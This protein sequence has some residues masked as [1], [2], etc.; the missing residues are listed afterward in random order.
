MD[1]DLRN[2][3][4]AME[5]RFTACMTETEGRLTARM[6]DQHE[7][8]LNRLASL[9]SDFQNIKGLLVEDA[10]ISGRRMDQGVRERR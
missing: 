4:E 5:G 10:I 7:R 1:E 8:V 6:N 9:E 3:L 2:Y